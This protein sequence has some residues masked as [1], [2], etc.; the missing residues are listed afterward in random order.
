MLNGSS[1][2]RRV[3]RGQLTVFKASLYDI[4]IAIESKHLN[5]RP[6]KEIV[7]QQYDEFLPLFDNMLADL[8]P[9]H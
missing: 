5:E 6:V 2:V 3:K 1:F 4:N 7:P 8:L 9:P